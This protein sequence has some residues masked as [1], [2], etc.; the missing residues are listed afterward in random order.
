MVRFQTQGP[1]VG[2]PGQDWN[3]EYKRQTPF[4]QVVGLYN[5]WQ[6]LS[7]DTRNWLA[8]LF[9]GGDDEVLDAPTD[10]RDEILDTTVNPDAGTLQRFGDDWSEIGDIKYIDDDRPKKY[11]PFKQGTA[12]LRDG[13]YGIDIP[14]GNLDPYGIWGG[15]DG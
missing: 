2:L 1:S 9:G 10:Q 6:S 15:L 8:G 7:P 11:T 12:E 13:L 4:K 14:V 5:M 3:A